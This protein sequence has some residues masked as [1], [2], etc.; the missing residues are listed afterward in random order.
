VVFLDPEALQIGCPR[1][2]VVRLRSASACAVVGAAKGLNPAE[3]GHPLMSAQEK[4]SAM[5]LDDKFDNKAEELKGKTKEGA[6]RATGDESLE[7]EGRADQASGSVKQA[8]E[9]VKDAAKSV[10]GKK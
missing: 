3:I 10:F 8:G 4:E 7:A 6:G 9:K 5:G 1:L 2:D